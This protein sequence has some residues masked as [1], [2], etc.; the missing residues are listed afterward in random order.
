MTGDVAIARLRALKAFRR[1]RRSVER[2]RPEPHAFIVSDR[3]AAA[4]AELYLMTPGEVKAYL[5][6][7][8][9]QN[10]GAVR[11]LAVVKIIDRFLES[12]P[13]A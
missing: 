6:T 1:G 9:L 11:Y 5:P 13:D 12:L 7:K 3:N 4:C 2:Q 10:G 8:K